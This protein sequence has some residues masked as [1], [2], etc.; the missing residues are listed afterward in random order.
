MGNESFSNLFSAYIK[1]STKIVKCHT[2]TNGKLSAI[3]TEKESRS[4]RAWAC[5]KNLKSFEKTFDEKWEGGRICSSFAC[6][7]SNF[8]EKDG[9]S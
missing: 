8:F 9:A 7:H 2:L 4:E 3:F 5:S 6:D 1:N